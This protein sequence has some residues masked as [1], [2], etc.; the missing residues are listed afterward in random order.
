M[1]PAQQSNRAFGLDGRLA[2]P[3]GLQKAV[4]RINYVRGGFDYFGIKKGEQ[5]MFKRLA[6]H[7]FEQCG[8]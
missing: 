5:G 7:D 1:A 6:A 2:K 8:N 4:D 3:F